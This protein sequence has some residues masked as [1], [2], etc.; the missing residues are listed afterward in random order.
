M[1]DVFNLAGCEAVEEN[2]CRSLG[3]KPKPLFSNP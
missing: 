3:F 2:A 1:P